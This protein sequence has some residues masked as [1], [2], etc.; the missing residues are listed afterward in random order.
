MS[1]TVQITTPSAPSVTPAALKFIQRMVRFGGAGPRAG[2]RLEVSP[3]GCSGMS[4]A[5]SVE[6]DPKAED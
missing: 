1:A 2:F 3:G 6:P 4:S 5:F